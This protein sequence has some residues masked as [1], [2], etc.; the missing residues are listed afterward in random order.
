MPKKGGNVAPFSG[1]CKD[2]EVEQSIFPVILAK[3][4][5]LINI[6]KTNHNLI[7]IIILIVA[8]AMKLPM[9]FPTTQTSPK[10]CIE[11]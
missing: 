6:T 5:S 1:F 2:F 4:Y 8:V 7:V 11:F 9:V 3:V 10:V